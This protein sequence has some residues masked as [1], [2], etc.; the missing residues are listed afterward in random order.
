MET[1]PNEPYTTDSIHKEEKENK[2][3]TKEKKI[4]KRF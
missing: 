2:W 3:Y 4:Q 1:K